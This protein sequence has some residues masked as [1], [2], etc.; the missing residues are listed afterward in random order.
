VLPED[1][2]RVLNAIKSNAKGVDMISIIFLKLCL[3]ALLPVLEHLFN[4]SL[5]NSVFP[6][7]WKLANIIPIAKVKAPKECKDYR[8]V[9]ILCVLG[10]GIEKVVHEQV[11]A[12]L[13]QNCLFPKYQSG[14]RKGHS[15]ITA[16]LKVTDDLRASMDKR[17]MNMLVLLDLSKAFDCVHH[18]LLLTKL[19]Y[20]GFSDSTVEWFNSYLTGRCHRVYI[21]DELL[22]DW[23]NVTTGVPQGS[24]LGP[25]LFIIYLFDLPLVIKK[26]FYHMFADDLQLYLPF[27]LDNYNEMCLVMAD[28]IVSVIEYCTRHNLLLNISKT[29]AIII[30]TQRY[31]TKLDEVQRIQLIVN[32]CEIHFTQAV[33]NLGIIMDST[34]SWS[35]HCISVA[36]KSLPRLPSYV[37]IFLLFHLRS[38]SS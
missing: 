22:S 25:L 2:A 23:I 27:S 9:S 26:C 33:N 16:L 32:G 7:L 11:T 15:T 6:S 12:F 5:Q 38:D 28:D 20:L 10:K 4:Y 21:S 8:P 37:V 24:V 35:D 18:G 17:L 14:F 29:Q 1:I 31:L 13:M 3:P 30:G 36:K 34:L 19:K